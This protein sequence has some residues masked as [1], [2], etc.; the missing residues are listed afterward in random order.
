[1]MGYLCLVPSPRTELTSTPTLPVLIGAYANLSCDVQLDPS[2]DIPV[3]VVTTW[4][5]PGG[6]LKNGSDT[7]KGTAE[8]LSTLMLTSLL[9]EEA[10]NYT[11]S[12]TVTPSNSSYVIPLTQNTTIQGNNSYLLSNDIIMVPPTSLHSRGHHNITKRTK[13]GRTELHL[14]L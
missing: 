2:V 13:G 8:Y 14:V 7:M 6:I 5:G 4:F 9:T 3:T 10:G 11:C 12:V 1:M